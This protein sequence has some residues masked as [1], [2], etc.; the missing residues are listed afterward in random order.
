MSSS[1]LNESGMK[2]SPQG[3]THSLPSPG[4]AEMQVS[5]EKKV[6]DLDKLQRTTEVT[7]ARLRRLRIGYR[8]RGMMVAVV[9]KGFRG[10][11]KR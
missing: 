3:P 10:F 5:H 11:V 7:H 6:A 9:P 8:V 1:G 2:A 4:I